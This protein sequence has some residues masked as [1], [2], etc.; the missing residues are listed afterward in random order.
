MFTAR[1][2]TGHSHCLVAPAW[3]RILGEASSR[4][5]RLCSKT[6]D[7]SHAARLVVC[8]LAPA[9]HRYDAGAHP[10]RLKTTSFACRRS[11]QTTFRTSSLG[12]PPGTAVYTGGERSGSR[13]ADLK[14]R[15]RWWPAVR[16]LLVHASPR[17]LVPKIAELI[18]VILCLRLW[19]RS[20]EPLL[21][22]SVSGI[23]RAAI[24]IGRRPGFDYRIW[25]L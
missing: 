23:L 10:P 1:H 8:A 4:W 20:E 25:R 16:L 7:A 24:G 15:I 18:Q 11:M 13:C 21:A 2:A 12:L 5:R 9:D 6:F 19:R 14:H 22:G 17:A 3:P